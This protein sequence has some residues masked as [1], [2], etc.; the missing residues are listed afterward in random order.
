MLVTGPD[1]DTKRWRTKSKMLWVLTMKGTLA[2]QS[3]T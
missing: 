3:D 2:V 1:W